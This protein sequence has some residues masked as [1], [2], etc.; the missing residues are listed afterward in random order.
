MKKI[1]KSICGILAALTLVGCS[2]QKQI[3]EQ[4][5]PVYITPVSVEESV[6]YHQPVPMNIGN[7]GVFLDN[8][9]FSTVVNR[10]HYAHRRILE[11]TDEPVTDLVEEY[12]CQCFKYFAENGFRDQE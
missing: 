11:L 3:S 7:I 1:N 4:A 10:L 5:T 12:Q 6:S 8:K 9:D 2:G